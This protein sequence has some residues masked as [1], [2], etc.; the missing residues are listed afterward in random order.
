M[1]TPRA[2][3]KQ[4]AT[5]R[6]QDAKDMEHGQKPAETVAEEIAAARTEAVE[7]IADAVLALLLSGRTARVEVEHRPGDEECSDDVGAA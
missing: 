6:Q 5:D 3:P 4:A 2:L 1:D 7:I